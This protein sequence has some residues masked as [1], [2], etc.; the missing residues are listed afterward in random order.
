MNRIYRTVSILM[1]D[2][3]PDDYC[4][5]RDAMAHVGMAADLVLVSDGEELMD[6]LF[7]RGRF[8]NNTLLCSPAVILL[9]LNMPRKDGWQTLVEIKANES[10]RRIPVIIYTTSAN[11]EH[12]MRSYELGASSYIIKPSTFESLI[13]LI[14]VLWR[15]WTSIVQLPPAIPMFNVTGPELIAETGSAVAEN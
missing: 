6:Y 2:D 8:I 3:D 11:E 4:L 9:D 15:Y 10:F 13:S 7:H 1:A 12:I 14:E 5:V